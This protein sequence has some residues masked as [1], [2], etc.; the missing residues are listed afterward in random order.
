VT[1]FRFTRGSSFYQIAPAYAG[2]HGYVG[3]SDGRGVARGPDR[4]AVAKVLLALADRAAGAV[5]A[6]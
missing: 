2:G 3:L 1:A 6:I 4:V 5:S